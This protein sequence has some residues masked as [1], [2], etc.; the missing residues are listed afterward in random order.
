MRILVFQHV[1]VEHP[2]VFREFW[3]TE[4]HEWDAVEFDRGDAIPDLSVYDVLVAMGGPMDV[5]QE[6]AHPWLSTEKEAIRHWVM[7]LNKPFLGVC[8]GHQ[9]LAEALGGKVGLMVKPEVGF[10][11]VDLTPH[12]LSD[13]ILAGFPPTTDTFQ[14]HGAE[15]TRLPEGAIILAANAACPVQ[16]MRWGAYAYGFQYH[17]EITETTYSDWKNIPEYQASLERALGATAA[18]KL[19][20]DIAIRLPAFREAAARLHSNFLRIISEHKKASS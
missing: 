7:D 12:G 2:G 11:S 1:D 14:W 5:W 10:S 17:V 13:P 19:G 4:G 9:L 20:D 3:K 6:E 16:A 15:V 8:L 18:T